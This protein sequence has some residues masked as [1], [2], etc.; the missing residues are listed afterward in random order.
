MDAATLQSR[1]YSGYAQAAQRIGFNADLYRPVTAHN[2][3]ASINKLS[4]L[5]ASFNAEDMR[6]GKPNKY[7]HPVWYGLFD[8]GLTQAGDYLTNAQDGTYF[9]A[10]QQTNLPILLVQCNR[11]IT[12]LR[13]Q[14]QTGVGAVGYGGD[15]DSNE[16][17]LMTSWP[18]SVLQAAGGEK[19]EVALPGDARNPLWSILLQHWPGVSLRSGDIITDDL[20][21]RYAINSAELTDLGWRLSAAQ[22]Q[23]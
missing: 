10:A 5:P 9:I 21:R 17:A 20:A 7:G 1:V 13:P 3:L 6:Y 4:S 15:T 22:V 14:Q 11:T 19:S 18:A 8:G 16:T 2:P 23:T 12:I